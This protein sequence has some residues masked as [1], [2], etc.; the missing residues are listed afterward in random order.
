[1]LKINAMD[2]RDRSRPILSDAKPHMRPADCVGYTD[3]I[4]MVSMERLSVSSEAS[5][6][7]S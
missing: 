6:Y 1:M 2:I 3:E 5:S 4:L 7:D